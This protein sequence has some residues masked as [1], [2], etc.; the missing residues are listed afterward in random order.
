MNLKEK[1]IWAARQKI[2]LKIQFLT[3]DRC[4]IYGRPDCL[5][6]EFR[7]LATAGHCPHIF[8]MERGGL[9]ILYITVG[10]FLW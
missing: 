6:F 7:K 4:E 2:I 9:L 10:F 1:T 3:L 5:L 8:M